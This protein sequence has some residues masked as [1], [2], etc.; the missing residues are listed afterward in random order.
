MEEDANDL[1]IETKIVEMKEQLNVMMKL[2]QK[3]MKKDQR[4]E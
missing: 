3:H 2:L 1:G 4:C